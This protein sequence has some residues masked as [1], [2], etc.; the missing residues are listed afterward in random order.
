MCHY[1]LRKILKNCSLDT[2]LIF[3]PLVY[4][5]IS[6]NSVKTI[7]LCS[8]FFFHARKPVKPTIL[9][10]FSLSFSSLFITYLS[11][12]IKTFC[13]AMNFPLWINLLISILSKKFVSFSH[14]SSEYNQLYIERALQ[15]EN[16]F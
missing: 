4:L 3:Q 14:N 6:A 12:D 11:F 8:F 2:P 15:H 9:H 7:S 1:F 10:L 5:T 16:I 13:K